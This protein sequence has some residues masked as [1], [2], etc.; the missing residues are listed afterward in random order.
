VAHRKALGKGL[1]ALIPP[2]EDQLLVL[3]ISVK[4]L[5]LNPLQP[6][7]KVDEA[8]LDELAASI[9]ENGVLQPILVRS[10]TSG[11]YQIVAGQRRVEA[12]RIAGLT[13]VPAFVRDVPDD[14]LL[15][16]ALIEN[17]QREDINSVEEALAYKYLHEDVGMSHEAIAHAVGKRRATVTNA[18]R[19]LNLPKAVLEMLR[20]GEISPGHARALLPL[21]KASRQ[22]ALAERIGREGLSVR[23]VEK[24]VGAVA[25]ERKKEPRKKNPFLDDLEKKI[26]DGLATRVKVT[27]TAKKGSITV[28]YYNYE[29]LDRLLAVLG[30]KT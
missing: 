2:H 14:K 23:Q 19:L 9:K 6:R 1:D 12:A 3:E 28:F 8:G 17:L 22:F 29:D 7:E 5:K 24:I 26:S 16:I 4:D 30:V 27:G 20:N 15:T 21:Q 10:T 13:T 18:L 11:R 25:P